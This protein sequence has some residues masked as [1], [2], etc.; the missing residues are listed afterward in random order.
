VSTV[1]YAN[2]FTLYVLFKI[3]FLEGN[4]SFSHVIR[5]IAERYIEELHKTSN[6]ACGLCEMQFFQYETTLLYRL[7]LYTT[8]SCSVSALIDFVRSLVL[9]NANGLPHV[10]KGDNGTTKFVLRLYQ[11]KMP[12]VDIYHSTSE[13]GKR[14]I[15]KPVQIDNVL[16]QDCPHFRMAV[17][18]LYRLNPEM[19]ALETYLNPHGFISVCTDAYFQMFRLSSAAVN[20]VPMLR[21]A[22]EFLFITFVYTLL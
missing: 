19:S 13:I 2:G 1:E 11:Y 6:T 21:Q 16:L 9:K 10:C 20:V 7:P 17:D 14:C 5:R 3:E 22:T 4:A 12:R 8:Q 18:D 15:L